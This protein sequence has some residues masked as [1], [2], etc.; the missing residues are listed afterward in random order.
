[1]QARTRIGHTHSEC[2][3]YFKLLRLSQRSNSD[4]GSTDNEDIGD[5]NL[6]D[7]GDNNFDTDEEDLP[8]L[9][10][11]IDNSS[12]NE[13]E[14][15]P[16]LESDSVDS[17]HSSDDEDEDGDE[18]ETILSWDSAIQRLHRVIGS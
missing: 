16:Y 12:E 3:E 9:E 13:D 14:D 1:M 5:D 7:L 15:L 10:S 2:D 6:L 11:L 17:D 8:N 4:G 18:D